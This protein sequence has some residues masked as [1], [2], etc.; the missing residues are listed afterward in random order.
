MQTR[1]VFSEA[2]APLARR[3]REQVPT[4]RLVSQ[5]A[6]E[7]R[8]ENAFEGAIRESVAWLKNRSSPIPSSAF[9]GTPFLVVGGGA[10]PAE[11]VRVHRDDSRLWAATLDDP[12]RNVARRTWVTEITVGE[13]NG[14][15]AFGAR[16]L[17]VSLGDDAPYESSRPGLIRQ[18]LT[19]QVVVADGRRL[20]DSAAF[21][22]SEEDAEEFVELLSNSNRR[23]PIIAVART[24]EGIE[25]VDPERL[26]LSVSGLAHVFIL[27]EEAS[28]SLTR[29]F[30]KS[31]S[32]FLGA[33]RLY[34]PGLDPQSSDPFDHP[35]WLVRGLD[36]ADSS[37]IRFRQIA[38][39]I[40]AQSV[41][42]NAAVGAFPRFEE[43]RQIA[44][45]E[46]REAAKGHVNSEA[47][48]L[49]LYK[50]DNEALR[51]EIERQ[52]EEYSETA[53]LNTEMLEI[54]ERERDEMRA[55]GFA[56]RS[57]V[58]LLEAAIQTRNVIL[59][60]QPLAAFEDIAEWVRVNLAGHIWIAPKAI[61]ETEKRGKFEDIALFQN[62]LLM[63]RD[64]FVPMKRNPGREKLEAYKANLNKL[65]LDDEPCFSQDGAIEQFPAYSLVYDSRKYWCNDHIKYGKGYDPRNMFRI[66]YH[67]HN[68]DQ[69]LLIG[70]MPTHLDNKLTN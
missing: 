54:A 5:A 52:K 6:F 29:Q 66:Y 39:R 21:I 30:G 17:N 15:V 26:A 64:L 62:T 3:F 31:L 16:L 11:A 69:I 70:H 63:L 50:I 34:N 56:L 35:L 33:A 47:E 58:Q 57:R 49:D 1:T 38:A 9:D 60:V 24:D 32:A 7:I 59:P 36:T 4:L 14:V 43:I 20:R 68:D 44:A 42:S 28:W 2:L 53:K 23:L 67:W 13:R 12:D 51:D 48:L 8:G 27:S 65:R 18:L 40:F 19:E 45:A 37:E 55:D 61:R 25:A 10:H 22:D 41:R 46:Q